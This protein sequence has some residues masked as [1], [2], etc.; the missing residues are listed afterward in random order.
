[1]AKKEGGVGGG[2]EG[3]GEGEGEEEGGRLKIKVTYLLCS[4]SS[5]VSFSFWLLTL[6]SR[7]FGAVREGSEEEY[8]VPGLYHVIMVLRRE[9]VESTLRHT[10]VLHSTIVRR[11]R[12][13]V[14][15]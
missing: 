9:S 11:T 5:R 12:R 10:R 6:F 14:R 4:P 1:M 8:G 2:G 3:E 13:P 7:L 15:S